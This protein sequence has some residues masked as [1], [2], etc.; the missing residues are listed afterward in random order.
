MILGNMY[1]LILNQIKLIV[2]GEDP[3]HFRNVGFTHSPLVI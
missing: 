2:L 1:K 3:S